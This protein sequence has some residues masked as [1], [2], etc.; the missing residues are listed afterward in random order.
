M[1]MKLILLCVYVFCLIN[2]NSLRKK[3]VSLHLAKEEP[4]NDTNT[5]EVSNEEIHR[6]WFSIKSP[7]LNDPSRFP[8]LTL[9]N[10][11]IAKFK[12]D[13]GNHLLNA[14]YAF[15]NKDSSL[16]LKKDLFYF[17]QN[18]NLLYFTPSKNNKNVLAAFT[19]KS[20][21][22]INSQQDN[23][24]YCFIITDMDSNKF[25][26][27]SQTNKEKMMFLCSLYSALNLPLL[28]ECS[29][30]EKLNE[31]KPT[32]EIIID[33]NEIEQI[34]VIPTAS[35]HCND[36]WDYQSHGAQ[37]ECTCSEGLEQSPIE[38]P[39][40]QEAIESNIAPLFQFNTIKAKSVMKD[41]KGNPLLET[42][43][44]IIYEN[45]A[46]RIKASEIAKIVTLDG[47]V[48]IAEEII[49]HTP[50]E[51]II[52]GKER[53]DMEMEIVYYGQSK[54]DINKQVVLSFL[55][56]KTPGAYNKFFESINY[57]DLP[58]PLSSSKNLQGDIYIPNVQYPKDYNEK[59]VLKPFS[60]Y[61]YQGSF[62]APPCTERTIRY[63]AS[64]LIPLSTVIIEQFKEALRTPDM[65]MESSETPE[66]AQIVLGTAETVENY[67]EI[68]KTNERSVFFWDHKKY[69]GSEPEKKE[70][71]E[72][73]HYEKVPRKS[74]EY[75]YVNSNEPTGLPD[76][77]VVGEKEAKGI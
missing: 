72:E 28:D 4:K 26:L 11:R 44:K 31:D 17:Y 64:D 71:V 18:K 2:I 3:K 42:T 20:I 60:F 16:P 13:S 6:G 27:C 57:F 24:N 59:I 15:N 68:Q 35:R 30:P 14:F 8:S 48:Y 54:G 73:G 50:A 19:V 7:I 49:F 34:Y 1:K 21:K 37:W 41:I 66:P 40:I 9:P 63:V 46:L 29:N 25:T 74:I 69:C 76:A 39:P 77:F 67:R 56:K 62:T 45:N 38:L 36:N 5:T 12:L 32:N 23:T 43:S 47:A 51:H 58:N 65:K 75:Y 52:K 53:P 10:G 55:F 33:Q 22:N 70:K 61:T